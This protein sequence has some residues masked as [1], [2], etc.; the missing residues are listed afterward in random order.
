MGAIIDG[1]PGGL[2]YELE[3]LTGELRRRAPGRLP[4]TTQRREADLP[5]I[6]SGVFEGK[7][8]G[9]PLAVIVKNRDA[10][11]LD[12][13][14]L[15][16]RPGHGD[17]TYKKKFDHHDLRGGGRS[18]GRETLARVIGGYFA[19]LI[20]PTIQVRSFLSEVGP[21]QGKIGEVEIQEFLLGLQKRGESI[22]GKATLEISSCPPGL[23]EP[24]F[25]K[26][27]SDLARAIMSVGAV[28]GVRFHLGHEGRALSG[29]EAGI[30]NG[31]EIA[32]D[33]WFK[34]TSTVGKKAQ[35]GRHDPCIIPR[36]L[37]VLEA[38][39]KMVLADHFLRQN[40]YQVGNP[41]LG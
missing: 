36:A 27:K 26:L 23:G 22:G 12:Y 33:C 7:T 29:I 9:S 40:A 4:G 14:N 25:D 2:S 31:E 5:E 38:M 18:S 24:A 34:A 10:R 17:L 20:I 16:P 30:S 3:E 28:T 41:R 32:L 13:Q 8:L 11:S 39:A 35:E 6:L 15:L 21:F 37:P 19:G 1:V